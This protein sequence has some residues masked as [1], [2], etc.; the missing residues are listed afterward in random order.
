MSKKTTK[1]TSSAFSRWLEQLQQ[2]SWQLELLVSGILLYGVV[3]SKTSLLQFK[4]Y[5]KINEVSGIV[6][7][8]FDVMILVA[9]I[10]WGIFFINFLT[11]IILR[12]FWIGAIGLRYVSGDIDF[13]AFNYSP[14]FESYLTRKVGTFDYFIERLEKACSVIFAYSF[15]LF[16]IFASFMLFIVWIVI[17]LQTINKMAIIPDFQNPTFI[18]FNML[19]VL[20]YTI[21]LVIFIDFITFGLF[22]RIKEPTISKIFFWIY[23]IT[24]LVTFS[25]LYRPLLYNFMDHKY[26]RKLILF[27][28]PYYIILFI[29]LPQFTMEYSA[30]FPREIKNNYKADQTFYMQNGFWWNNYDDLRKLKFEKQSIFSNKPNY[31]KTL[32][33]DS[34]V[35]NDKLISLFVRLNEGEDEYLRNYIDIKP[36]YK[37]GL[38]NELFRSFEKDSIYN[39]IQAQMD[40]KLKA[41]RKE[42]RSGKI[43]NDSIYKSKREGIVKLYTRQKSDYRLERL[44][45][46]KSSFCDIYEIYI[47]NISVSDSSSCNYFTHPNNF[48]KGLLYL[49]PGIHLDAGVHEIKVIKKKYRKTTNDIEEVEYIVPFIKKK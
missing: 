44:N 6:D 1:K 19:L 2:E 20:S 17:L 40:D 4:V 13:K 14:R 46:I 42:K 8:I 38:H 49:L 26:T 34:Y 36:L 29:L 21:G 27:S 48:E 12:G 35:Q 10:A 30:F 23:R 39:S 16:F 25:F 22:K 37:S 15:L 47:D 24:S 3:E 28:I 31:I 11:H 32:S 43:S 45:D 5:L 18:F 41:L 9:F 33:L 7:T